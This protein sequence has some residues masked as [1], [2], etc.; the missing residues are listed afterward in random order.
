MSV[1]RALRNAINHE[2][3]R[4]AARAKLPRVLFDFIDG[5]AEDELTRAANRAAFDAVR[6]L[7]KIAAPVKPDLSTKLL[8]TELSFP[9]MIAPLGNARTIHPQGGKALARAA[10]KAG[11]GYVVPH[12]GGSSLEE[13]FEA[14]QDGDGVRADR[15]WYQ[16][17]SSGGRE[18]L[19][20]AI[21]RA[22]MTGYRVL[23]VTVENSATFHERVIRGGMRALVSGPKSAMLPHLPQL[24]ARPAWLSRYLWAGWH[25]AYPNTLLNGRALTARDL[26][27]KPAPTFSWDDVKRIRKEW[28]GKIMLKGILR[29]DDAK[30]A[31]DLGAD[32]IIVSNHGGR[33]LDGSAATLDMLPGIAKAVGKDM[34][35]IL[36]SGI[37]RGRDVIAALALGAKAVL[38][39]RPSLFA[40]SF[41]EAGVEHS[42]ALLKG[43]MQR[44]MVAL[45]CGSIRE[46]DKSFLKD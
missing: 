10:A 7:P 36:D 6:F 21:T 11:I 2:D 9:V 33:T 38:W 1:P 41:G 8:G 45:G 44:N 30:R 20:P 28:P 32:A 24:L 37:R 4:E 29:Q 34:D 13:V 39:G 31:V 16:I 23:V 26:Q 18:V 40:L 19:D 12:M 3:V 46:I 15:L 35:V 17:Y 27:A 14:V 43:E 42:L 22:W 25:H 5:A